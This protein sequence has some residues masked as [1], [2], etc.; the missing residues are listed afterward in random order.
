MTIKFRRYFVTDGAV[1]ARVWYSIDNHVSGEPCVTIY[2]KDYTGELGKLFQG[3]AY[4]NDTDLMTDYFDKG[5]VRFFPGDEWY[6]TA[7]IV[8]EMAKEAQV[9]RIQKLHTK[10]ASTVGLWSS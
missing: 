7:R 1:K 3:P 9:R 4:Q 8:A 6:S 2:A 5:R 10:R